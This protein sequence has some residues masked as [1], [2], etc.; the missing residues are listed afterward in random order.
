MGIRFPIPNH[1][2]GRRIVLICVVTS[3]ARYTDV[4]EDEKVQ[5]FGSVTCQPVTARWEGLSG[6]GNSKCLRE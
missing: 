5:A 4:R 2:S 6:R 1:F 3:L